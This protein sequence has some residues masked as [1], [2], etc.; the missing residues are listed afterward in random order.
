M[1]FCLILLAVLVSVSACQPAEPPAAAAVVIPTTASLPTGNEPQLA[2]AEPV[3]RS[4]LESWRLNDYAAMYDL[5]TFNSQEATPLSA[6]TALYEQAHATMTLDALEY[7]GNAMSMEGDVAIFNYDVT[8]KTRVLGEFTDSNRNLRLVFDPRAG[9]WRV[10]W[11]AGDIFREMEGGNQLRLRPIIPPRANIYDTNGVTLADQQ[12]RVVQVNVVR[13][14]IPNYDACLS[15]LSIAL[16]RPVVELQ[17]RLESRPDNWLMDMGTIDAATW[18]NMHGQLEAMCAAQFTG[19]PVRRYA[20]GPVTAHIVG[21]VG[22]PE[23]SQIDELRAVGFEQDSII[24]RSG[25][26]RAWDETLRGQPGGELT[27]VTPSG[28][29]LRQLASARSSPPQSVWLTIDADLQARITRIVEAAYEANAAGWGS[30][31][32][33]ASVVIMN[34]RTGQIIAMVS[35]PSFD[36]NAFTTFPEMGRAAADAYVR[37]VEQDPRQPQLNRPMLGAYPLGSVMKLVSSIAA[38]N[39]GVYSLTERYTCTGVWSRDITRYDWLAGGHGTITL[40]QA[41]TRSCN[42]YYY[43]VGYRLDSVDPYLLPNYAREMGLGTR[44]GL[45]NLAEADGLVVDPDWW[46]QNLGLEWNFSESV[47]MAIGQGYLQ[48]TPLQVVRM[49]ATIA[50]DGVMLKPQLVKQV[51]LIGENPSY[52]ATPEVVRRVDVRPEVLDIVRQGM[53]DVTTSSLGTAEFVFR[54]S[55]LQSIGVCAKTGTA[56]TGTTATSHAWFAAYAPRENPEIAVVVM[57]ENGGEGSG[58]AAPITRD[59]L[60]AYFFG[61]GPAEATSEPAQ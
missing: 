48:V 58:T 4:F 2:D 12:G 25:I 61:T 46:R 5:I 20:N 9:A 27:I 1:R 55:D 43:E 35:Y 16:N 47:N 41:I 56:Q 22:Y 19:L 3:A 29:V 45:E 34:V 40:A 6:F 15:T 13:G 37:Q 54:D 17:T 31:S 8:F 18:E 30:E 53:C 26:E 24:G 33:G 52:V 21:Y 50:N 14:V 44:T 36:N 49:I 11:T 60:E 57:V 32:K 7:Q 39:S 38:A 51:G 10:A 28:Q 42:P 59:V 23:E